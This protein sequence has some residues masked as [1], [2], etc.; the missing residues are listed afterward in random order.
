[1]YI[2]IPEMILNIETMKSCLLGF[3]VPE[4]TVLFLMLELCRNAL[5]MCSEVLFVSSLFDCRGLV[6]SLFLT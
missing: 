5:Q 6:F 2:L 4:L 1:M 3:S